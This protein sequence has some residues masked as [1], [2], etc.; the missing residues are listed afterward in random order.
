[1]YTQNI[2]Y[3]WK[4][5]PCIWENQIVYFLHEKLFNKI[6]LNSTNNR[7]NTNFIYFI[8]CSYS[9]H[10]R[11]DWQQIFKKKSQQQY[12]FQSRNTFSFNIV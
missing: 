5:N 9:I 3:I 6:F 12:L 1:M 4:E 2:K 7:I 11:E 8:F 10:E